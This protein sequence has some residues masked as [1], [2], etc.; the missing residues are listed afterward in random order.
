[1]NRQAPADRCPAH[2]TRDDPRPT[3][4]APKRRPLRAPARLTSG[5]TAAG[6][7]AAVG[8]T[9][10]HLSATLPACLVAAATGAAVAAGAGALPR[11]YW[12]SLY[13]KLVRAGV[14]R[15]QDVDDVRRLIDSLND[16]PAGRQR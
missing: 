9:G 16:A 13:A 2:V 11:L 14:S 3:A 4:G 15:A 12:I 6:A 5:I 10:W 1:M 8:S 7:I